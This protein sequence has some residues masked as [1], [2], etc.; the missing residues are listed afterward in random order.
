MIRR[1]PLLLILALTL[2]TSACASSTPQDVVAQYG[3]A[4]RDGNPKQ[5][6]ALLSPALRE[7]TPYADFLAQWRAR[8]QSL[9][10]S[11]T[12]FDDARET[13]ARVSATLEYNDYDTLKMTLGPEG[14]KLSGGVLAI[15]AQDTPRA[16]LVSFVRALEA[17]DHVQLMHFIPS[18]YAQHMTPEALA[19][20]LDARKTEVDALVIEL[21]ANLDQPIAVRGDH[22]FL[23][24]GEHKVTLVLEGDVWKVEDPD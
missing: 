14:W 21:K 24:Y 19:T 5:A 17:R 22:A 2:A 16:A 13:P 8:R 7:K 11:A 12:T 4:V 6:Y 20:D 3:Q 1:A 23:R 15:Y 10:G 9:M 18:N